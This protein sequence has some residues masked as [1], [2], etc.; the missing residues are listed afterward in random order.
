MIFLSFSSTLWHYSIGCFDMIFLASEIA[1][2]LVTLWGIW[3]LWPCIISEQFHFVASI[4]VH[5]VVKRGD[6]QACT[7]W[8]HHLHFFSACM[9][10]LVI[11]TSISFMM[12]SSLGLQQPPPCTTYARRRNQSSLNWL[13]WPESLLYSTEVNLSTLVIQLLLVG[14]NRTLGDYILG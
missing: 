4:T 5:Q 13:A 7:P 10:I 9:R 2:S 3:W 1:T 14:H 6:Q 12:H 11:F 8:A